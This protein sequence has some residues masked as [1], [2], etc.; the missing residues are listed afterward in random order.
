M[1]K[2]AG[3]TMNGLRTLGC[4]SATPRPM[5]FWVR[6]RRGNCSCE[7]DMAAAVFGSAS[8]KATSR[9]WCL[10]IPKATSAA[11]SHGLTSA[12]LA[13]CASQLRWRLLLS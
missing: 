6:A 3:A 13:Q 8:A 9:E 12:I 5:A 11:C 4:V 7:V 10:P 2:D 1:L